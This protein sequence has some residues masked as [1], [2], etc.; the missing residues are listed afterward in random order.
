MNRGC[1]NCL[2]RHTDSRYEP[3]AGCTHAAIDKWEADTGVLPCPFCNG[4]AQ[5]HSDDRVSIVININSIVCKR[6][7]A[8]T[9]AYNTMSEARE[10]WN[11]RGSW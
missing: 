1:E 8:R 7:G 10:A 3:C 11:L 5:E 2:Y 9:K 4:I 6:C